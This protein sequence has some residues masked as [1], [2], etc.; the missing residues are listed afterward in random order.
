MSDEINDIIFSY[1]AG[2]NLSTEDRLKAEVW[3]REHGQEDDVKVIQNL[4]ISGQLIQKAHGVRGKERVLQIEQEVTRLLYKRKWKIHLYYSGVAVGVAILLCVAL[5]LLRQVPMA[6]DRILAQN[7]GQMKNTSKVQLKLNSGEII[8]LDKLQEQALLKDSVLIKNESHTLIHNSDSVT[9]VNVQYNTL[10]LPRGTEYNIV[11]ADGTKVYLNADSEIRY[12]VTFV[13]NKREVELKGEAY[14]VVAKNEQQPFLVRVNDQIS[15]RVLG[16][17]F[18][19]TAYPDQKRIVTTLEEGSVQVEYGEKSVNITPGEQAVY[20]KKNGYLKV[21]E[22]DTQLYTS[23]KDG[24]YKFS[25]ATLEE[26]METLTLWYDLNVFY[27][28]PEVKNLE[29]TGRLKRYDD[30]KGLFK[31]F[32]DTGLVQFCLKGNNVVI[33]KK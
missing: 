10:T 19:V 32:E 11:L 33:N 3:L 26:I 13:D 23:W 21:K 15:V 9:S 5:V 20:D 8:E 14:F 24:Y 7:I 6:N 17:S 4:F 16:T 25:N 2:E 1:L 22:V 12:P 29:F 28:N 31:K 18:N 30:V 27:V